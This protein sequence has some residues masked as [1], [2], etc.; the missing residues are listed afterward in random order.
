[1]LKEIFTPAECAKCRLCCNFHRESVWE[2]PFLVE[3]LALELKDQGIPVEL[4]SRGGWSFVY[5]F[6]DNEAVDCPLLD[7][8]RGCRFSEKDKPFEC[9]IWP[10]RIMEMNGST[11]IGK[12]RNCP[13][14]QGSR[15]E[16][17]NRLVH[18]R[19]LQI[20]LDFIA[21]Y[22]AARRPFST[23]YEVIWKD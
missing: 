10:L 19:L 14:I 8:D 23:E 9:R 20:L 7:P 18:D 3:D 12:Y 11:V 22:P 4:R 2:S 16:Q 5:Q 15:G 6:S 13:A 1:M 17:I 21:K